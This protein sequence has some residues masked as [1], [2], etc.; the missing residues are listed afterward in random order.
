MIGL[1][2]V[3]LIEKRCGHNTLLKALETVH[4]DEELSQFFE[5]ELNI[6]E[7]DIDSIIR[8]AVSHYAESGTFDK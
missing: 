4:T 7:K 3:D 8:T 2:I 6:E 1:V 5:K